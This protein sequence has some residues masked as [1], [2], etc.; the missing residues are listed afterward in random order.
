MIRRP[1]PANRDS[2]AAISHFLPTSSK[3]QF[4]SRSGNWLGSLKVGQKISVG[5]GLVI[6]VAVLGTTIGFM[7]ADHYQKEAQHEEEDAI[8]ELAQVNHLNSA[9][10]RVRTKQHKLILY[11]EQPVLWQEK[12]P[13]LLEYVAQAQ[14]AWIEFKATFRNP[15]RRLKDSPQE[16]AAYDQ[17]V[18][19]KNG[20][21]HY[22]KQSETLFKASNPKNLS[23]ADINATQAKLFNFM[24]NSQVFT[25][26]DFLNDIANLVE[27]A[28][29]EYKQAKID[30]R[31]AEKL[32]LQ[33]IAASLLLSVATAT[34]LAMYMNRAIARP[35]QA[36]TH[37]AHQ[38][39]EESNFDL[40]APV[41]TQDEIGI[42][43]ASL[44]RL[45]QEVQQLLKTQKDTNEQLEVYSEVLEK[46]VRERTREL[47]EKN[48]SLQQTLEDLRRTQAQLVQTEKMSS[49]GQIVAGVAHE[50]NSPINFIGNNLTHTID[51]VQHLLELVE[52][53]QHYPNSA[54][55]VPNKATEINLQRL[56]EDFFNLF[57]SMQTSSDRITEIVKSLR[58]FSRFDEA[59]FK[60]VDIHEGID[61]TL[62]ILHN[63]LKTAIDR[64]EIEVVREYGELPQIECYPGQLNQVFMNLISN[65]IDALEERMRNE[66]LRMRNEDAAYQS[67]Q[68]IKNSQFSILN[69]QLSLPTIRI[70][71]EVLDH[72]WVVIHIADNGSGIDAN[73]RS[74]IFDPF[75]T[76]KPAG[77]GTGLGLSISYQIITEKHKG[78]LNCYSTPGQGT[79]FAIQIPL[80]QTGIGVGET[81]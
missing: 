80:R 2:A 57:G 81:T 18:Q 76:T 54:A 20:F 60:A 23:P 10:F 79:E 77:K 5:Y 6:G 51:S 31:N 39:T 16:K 59:E 21:D 13:Q 7:I 35:I 40:Q 45:I 29:A 48:Q 32:R 27:V 46:K 71:T 8:E 78:N 72:Q 74:R 65:A 1:Q 56:K 37:V 17:L 68:G 41:T 70:Q 42:L 61:S 34:L 25:L 55:P 9:V 63:R 75:F 14:Q 4:P 73:Q 24:H 15:S 58:H 36:V 38:V 12:Y 66:E 3:L 11:M 26:D 44:N 33:I 50:I 62:M 67:G 52:R 43:A 49:L 22:L 69:S 19:T 53:Y 28:A 47:K 64:L 30:L